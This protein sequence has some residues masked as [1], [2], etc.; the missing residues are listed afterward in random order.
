MFTGCGEAVDGSVTAVVTLVKFV[1]TERLTTVLV[2]Q[3]SPHPHP[4]G[5]EGYPEPMIGLILIIVVVL[6]LLW[7]FSQ[8]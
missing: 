5:G 1:H 8:R 7:L 2:E 6:I 4:I 3:S